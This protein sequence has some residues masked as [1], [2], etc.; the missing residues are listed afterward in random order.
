MVSKGPLRSTQSGLL[1]SC[2]GG[3][4]RDK[5]FSL[6]LLSAV[7]S[8]QAQSRMF[9]VSSSC[10]QS[11]RGGF[12]KKQNGTVHAMTL[13]SGQTYML[14]KNWGPCKRYLYVRFKK[15]GKWTKNWIF[16]V[17]IHVGFCW[18]MAAQ[19]HWLNK[20]TLLVSQSVSLSACHIYDELIFESKLC[21]TPKE[22]MGPF[23]AITLLLFP[24]L[25]GL[26]SDKTLQGNNPWLPR[27]RMC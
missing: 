3:R 16:M 8:T 17:K 2:L 10:Q 19:T 27:T 1:F 20:N 7:L 6:G 22:E 21:L 12:N 24:I 18:V 4:C 13:L 9:H 11:K 25:E 14:S 5:K 23:K 26:L 15:K